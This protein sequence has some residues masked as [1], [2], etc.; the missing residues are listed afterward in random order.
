MPSKNYT[1]I[2]TR[3]ELLLSK[4]Q[5]MNEA[6]FTIEALIPLF[7]KLGF[8]VDYHGGQAEGGKDFICRKGGDFGFEETCVVQVKKI[9]PSAAVGKSNSFAGIVSQLQQAAE[10]KVPSLS[11]RIQ[12]PTNIYF[13]TPYEINTRALES[14]FEG[15]ASL[16]PRGVR[17]LDGRSVVEQLIIHLPDLVE[18]ICGEGFV[19]KQKLLSNISNADLLSALEYGGE[20]KITDFYCDLDFGVGKVTTKALFSMEFTPNTVSYLMPQSRWGNFKS[21]ICEVEES[22]GTRVLEPAIVDIERNFAAESQRWLS[23]ANQEVIRKIEKLRA[24]IIDNI[25]AFLDDSAQ[26][27]LDTLS[28]EL[29]QDLSK[30]ILDL[31]VESKLTVQESRRLNNIRRSNGQ[32]SIELEAWKNSEYVDK[33]Q[34]EKI[35][36]TLELCADHLE[37]IR[38]EA[39]ILTVAARS[40]L[41]QLL[42]RTAKLNKNYAELGLLLEKRVDEPEYEMRILG[43]SLAEAILKKRAWLSKGI[44]DLS[45]ST[46]A[47]HIRDFFLACQAMFR[48]IEHVLENK[49]LS[50]ALG[51][52]LRKD[53]S[54][55]HPS[56]RISMPL[57]KVFGTGIHCAVY[58]EAG[59]G[60]ST[61]LHQYAA[62]SS[63]SESEQELT[64]F[65]PLTRI[66]T[67]RVFPFDDRTTAVQKLEAYLGFFLASGRSYCSTDVIE[68]IKSKK[69]V[70]FI[71]DGVDEVI[72]RAPWIVEAISDIGAS[73]PNSQIIVSS[74]ASA[75]YV[76]DI[77][78]LA[79][80]LLP[81][82]D[83]QVSHFIDGWFIG[84]PVSGKMVK[85]HLLRTA[86]LREIV[87]SPLLATIL[88][89]LAEHNVPLPSGEP[90][91]YKERLELLLGRYD[92]HKKTKRVESRQPLL[93]VVA[94]KL[95]FYLHSHTARSSSPAKLQEAAVRL[96]SK[97]SSVSEVQKIR[98][99]VKELDD[100]CN[101]LV[102]M[103]ADGD[104]G[105]GH[106]RYQ[107]YLCARELCANRGIDLAPLLS[108]PWWKG[109][110][111][112]FAR[113]TDDVSYVITDIVTKNGANITKYRDNLLA[114]IATRSKE[115]RR[116]LSALIEDHARLDDWDDFILDDER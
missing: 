24:D 64:L 100:P 50:E 23:P 29:S 8:Q 89:V 95:A 82:T 68:F 3:H 83:E 98:R 18:K 111:I 39:A 85:T 49:N 105:F 16:T 51:P 12:L 66:L 10:K 74:R 26:A 40:Q 61:T 76:N 2:N 57:R 73:Y 44:T 17:I 90:D 107:E 94:R 47:T 99:A 25:S 86:E 110:L 52:K 32:I 45:K 53:A 43:D 36:E 31:K 5:T 71:F 38:S 102:P 87:R 19:F 27:V 114:M 115:E 21:Y 63:E 59:A 93:E 72:K 15:V 58:G 84:D 67:E 28:V 69:R 103:T 1:Q 113:M 13:I 92:M 55:N 30:N 96:C 46:S 112:L 4:L 101:V 20:K 81:F 108:S 88:C 75:A 109:V 33:L 62:Y 78:Y 60:K 79:L 70:A 116:N 42:K 77:K 35:G 56:E 34:Y 91:M 48:T 104:F 106:L 6:T 14:R 11:G 41:T 7:K 37:E 97:N 65:L 80:T 54:L 22:L 9:K